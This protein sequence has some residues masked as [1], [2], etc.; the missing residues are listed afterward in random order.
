MDT[1][2][3]N[4]VGKWLK[5]SRLNVLIA[6][7]VAVAVL[8]SGY[9][10]IRSY[11]QLPFEGGELE[12]GTVSANASIVNDAG[13]SGGKAIQFGL[14]S[15]PTKPPADLSYWPGPD[16]T[17]VPKGITLQPYTGP[18]TITTP[19]TVIEG[20]LIEQ[21]ISI[22]ASNV[23]IKKS[24]LVASCRTG[25]ISTG[26]DGKYNNILIEDVEIDGKNDLY[27]YLIGHTGFT[28]NRCNLHGGFSGAHPRSGSA[29]TNS[30]IHDPA[31][32]GSSAGRH[33]SGIGF[34]GGDG[35]VIRHNRVECEGDGCSAALSLYGNFEQVA[36][37]LVED[38]YFSGGG[39]CTYGGSLSSKPYPVG[40]NIRYIKNAFAKTGVGSFPKC[41]RF[42][43]VA[44]F[45]PGNG[46]KWV[47]NYSFDA[48]RTPVPYCAS[49]PANAE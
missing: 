18:T 46:N 26:L 31:T 45:E 39:Y 29:I 40:K 9:A 24:K 42:G 10:I 37:V 25:N 14:P 33:V 3:K 15:T 11:A 44:G 4:K 32:G 2:T 6:A 34:H 5:S 30:Y 19:G 48:A 12:T 17:G 49:C 20:K 16:N 38:N 27:N 43:P 7:V 1:I 41:G 21:C 22:K 8:L 47:G 28:C 13:A 35:L 36:N 23:T